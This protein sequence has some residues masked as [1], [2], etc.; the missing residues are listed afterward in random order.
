MNT[1]VEAKPV[2]HP[3]PESQPYWDGAAEGKLR[4]QRCQACGKLR[5]YA[6]LVCPG[7]YSL[8]VEWIEASGR[9]TVHSGTVAHHAFLPAFK[10]DLPYTLIIVDLEEGPCTMGRLDPSAQ[11]GLRIGLP[12]LVSFERNA[13]G[14]ALP[15]FCA[16]R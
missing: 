15:V 6:Q 1:A 14:I 8:D 4:L 9:G 16:A 12:V 13:E 10:A 5:N 3:S 7:C 2:P 11:A